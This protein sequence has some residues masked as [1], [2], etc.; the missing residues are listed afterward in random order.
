MTA[1]ESARKGSGSVD[2]LLLGITAGRTILQAATAANMSEAT[3]HRR[4]A[5]PDVRRRLDAMRLA[6]VEQATDALAALAVH[7]VFILG[8][9][10]TDEAVAAGVRARCAEAILARLT[11][12][13]EATLIEARLAELEQAAD[14]QEAARSRWSA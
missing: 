3:A 7:A 8:N 2:Q 12:V 4:L 1:R 9:L 10:M 5:E 14:A 11:S 6:V 13:R